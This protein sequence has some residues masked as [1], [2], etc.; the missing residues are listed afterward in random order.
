VTPHLA[1]RIR[2]GLLLL[3]AILVQTTL[4]ADLR[5]VEVAPDLM[6]VLVICSGM[7]GGVRAGAWVGFWAGLLSDMFLTSTPIGLSAFTY[8]VVG[9]S[10]GFVR[11]TFLHDRKVLLPIAA[12]LG[13]AVAIL[14]FV[15]AGDV[16]GQTQLLAGGRSWLI[17]VIIVESVWSAVLVIPFSYIYSWAA[18]GSAGVELVGSGGGTSGRVER[19]G[20]R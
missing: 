11:E 7:A 14:L 3:V 9:A 19:I 1:S 17:R 18:R 8:C 16:L 2:I 20:A 10:I 6:V 13:T 4:G 5:I 15:G 12:A